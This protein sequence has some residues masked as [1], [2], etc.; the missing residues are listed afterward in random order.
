MNCSLYLALM[1]G[2][3]CFLA[4]SLQ[5]AP[6]TRKTSLLPGISGQQ[7][8]Q[9]PNPSAEAAQTTQQTEESTVNAQPPEPAN[10]SAPKQ[11][12]A[13]QSAIDQSMIDPSG[14]SRSGQSSTEQAK[15]SEKPT[16]TKTKKENRAVSQP[17]DPKKPGRS[18]GPLIPFSFEK[19]PLVDIID[20]LSE[21]K[22]IN[23]LL[24]QIPADL[25]AIKKQ[26]ITY[27]PQGRRSV[28]LEEAWNLLMT[29]LELSGYS[30]SKK[31]NDLYAIVRTGRPEEAGISR[32]ILPL[33]ISTP[34][35][36][37]P[38]S[39][40]RIR[41]IYYLKN[42]K[43][44]TQED[45]ETNPIAR[46]FKDMLSIG[47]PVVY[48]PKS[49]G[50]IITDRANAIASAMRIISDLDESGFRET[51]E[52]V[53]LNFVPA[54]DIVKVFDSLKKAAG[55]AAG[56]TSPFIRADARAESISY[57]AADTRIIADDRMNTIIIMG[58]ESAVE[59]I[60]EFVQQYMDTAP[61][62][63]KSIL[64]SY[65]LQY[66]DAQPFAEVLNRIVASPIQTGQQATAG[67]PAGPERYFQ[68]VVVAAEEV[69]KVEAKAT[70]EEV[71][72]ES[73]GDYTPAGITGQII[74]GGNRLIIAALADDWLKLKDF[75]EALDKPQ[76][77]VILEVLVVDI[78]DTKVKL[79][80]GDIRNRTDAQVPTPGF[81][82]LSNNL[83]PV[84]NAIG[85]TPNQLATDLLQ[86]LQGNA[87]NPELTALLGPGSIIISLND[88]KTPGISALLQVLDT[89]VQSKVLSHPC[90]VTTN[91]QKA[92]LISQEIRRVQGDAV[93]GAA[94]VITIP[95]IDLPATF[96][97]QMI[98][99]LS[100]LERLSLQVAVDINDF[101]TDT[102]FTRTTR[103]VSTN[104]NLQ[105]GQILVIGGLNRIDQGETVSGTPLIQRIPLIGSLFSNK[106]INTTKTNIHVFICPTIVAPKLRG[107]LDVYT[108]DKI[109]K[110][111]RDI[112]ER[113]IFSDSRDPI[114]HIFFRPEYKADRLVRD[115]LN[116]VKNKPDAELIK[117]TRE[118]R[119]EARKPRRRPAP[120]K[121]EAPKPGIVHELPA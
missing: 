109:R 50:F 114:M 30:I 100:S 105:S 99:R 13:E 32:E 23:I 56:I 10:Q 106:N 61:E 84:N 22:E 55:E 12:L 80:A 66:L 33:Y 113:T 52:V 115:F 74:T 121:K 41:Y 57:F 47:A 63:G 45:R 21:K 44:P 76:P 53:Q 17:T 98:P 46:I 37:L 69:K 11:P 9:A 110:G 103:R 59:R 19:K 7:N 92:T 62:E 85:V 43:I 60:R 29:F 104:S 90:L 4:S 81:Q 118:K 88:P 38:D 18:K 68:G 48:E 14:R 71:V 36:E 64:H 1:G 34:Y 87:T 119:K 112:D 67:G 75:I 49:N 93:S 102:S 91:N 15:T 117:T 82:W 5:A 25:E 40:Q 107:G 73:K 27:H 77:Q 42:F 54:R 72:L 58:R 70:T 51:I 86:V 83:T 95:V 39:E 101:I 2:L 120:P 94:G 8:T 24:P 89:I 97:I 108:A 6:N 78:T 35:N 28:S 20:L 111:R 26:T 116:D 16:A 65:D 3:G 79:V 96:Q 31:R